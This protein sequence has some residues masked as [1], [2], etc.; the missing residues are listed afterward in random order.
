MGGGF[1]LMQVLAGTGCCDSGLAFLQYVVHVP[2]IFTL[3]GL[4]M[5]GFSRF[6]FSDVPFLRFAVSLLLPGA[7]L[8]VCR[9][10]RFLQKTGF[11]ICS[12]LLRLSP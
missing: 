5:P 9:L 4:K 11:R 2:R 10:G 8:E 3:T 7:V 1:L 12:C 6:G